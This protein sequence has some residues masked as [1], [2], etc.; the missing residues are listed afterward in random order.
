[1]WQNS[2]TLA[3]ELLPTAQAEV[4]ITESFRERILGIPGRED[5]PFS[6]V[7]S[8][9]ST[10]LSDDL[11]KLRA[12]KFELEQEKRDLTIAQGVPRANDPPWAYTAPPDPLSS[13]PATGLHAR[14]RACARRD[15]SRSR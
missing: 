2:A 1:V 10:T 8:E 6:P 5:E 3:D 14:W 11:L 13:V 9:S 15:D 12:L 7:S 4:T